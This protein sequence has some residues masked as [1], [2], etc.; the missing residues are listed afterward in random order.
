MN[1]LQ[2][3]SSDENVAFFVLGDTGEGDDSQYHLIRPLLAK[4]EDIAFTY[5]VSDVI[6]PAG[7][8]RDYRDKFFVPYQNVPGPIYAV[9]GNHDWYDGLCGFMTMLCNADPGLRRDL[10]E[11]GKGLKRWLTNKLWRQPEKISTQELQEIRNPA[12]TSSGQ[13]GPYFV[14]ELNE[15]YLVGIDTGL[16]GT[17]DA[18]QAQWLKTVSS[19][20]KEKILFTG[21]PLIA[22][23]EKRIINIE[24]GSETVNDIVRAPE[25]RYIAV[26][27]GDTH[28]YQRYPVDEP[29]GTVQYIVSGAGGAYTKATHTIPRIRKD[30]VGCDEEDFRCYPL[31]GD[32]LAAY[33]ILYDKKVAAGLGQFVIPRGEAASIIVERLGLDLETVRHDE[34]TDLISPRSRRA[35]KLIMGMSTVDSRLRK[36]TSFLLDYNTPNPPLFKSFLRIDAQ[37]GQIDITCYAATGCAEHESNPPVE[38]RVR[39]TRRTDEQHWTWKT[40]QVIQPASDNRRDNTA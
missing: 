32:S 9:P 36:D 4:S 35:A 37:P 27:G 22:N 3:Y 11:N 26:I 12:R 13:P 33:S 18:E 15:L 7:D 24:G 25:N 30:T 20:G 8:A 5:I 29:G 28:N 34:S 17:I 23:G 14:I 39:A 16:T 1:P 38:D 19:W 2:E 21:T 40:L 6:Y 10:P 31:R